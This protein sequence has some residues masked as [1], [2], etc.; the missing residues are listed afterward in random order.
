[1]IELLLSLILV[2]M[3]ASLAGVG[4]I[5][6]VQGYILAKDNAHL[7]QKAALVSTRLGRELMEL[8]EVTSASNGTSIVYERDGSYYAVSQVGDEI[9]IRA[10]T[11][12]PDAANGDA[13]VDD[14]AANGFT[15]IYLKG[16]QT[17]VPGTDDLRDLTAIQF[18][19]NLDHPDGDIGNLTF[20]T[21][22]NPRNTG[23]RAGPFGT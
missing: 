22:V 7:A 12:L 11:S 1:M 17:W 5:S 2:G 13:L 23:V 6:G 20:T 4:L 14:V 19:L 16:A 15:L 8:T 3:L 18:V 10:G 9:K 21:T